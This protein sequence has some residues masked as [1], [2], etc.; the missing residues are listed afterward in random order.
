MPLAYK[1][2][3][4]SDLL[5][6]TEKGVGMRGVWFERTIDRILEKHGLL[7][8]EMKETIKKELPEELA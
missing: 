3:I 5:E 1:D 2:K 4:D 7:S 8:E 6:L